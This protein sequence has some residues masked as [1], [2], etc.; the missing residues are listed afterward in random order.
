MPAA[1]RLLVPDVLEVAAMQFDFQDYQ[2]DLR[3]GR[4]TDASNV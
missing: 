3:Y 2:M 4:F 1:S